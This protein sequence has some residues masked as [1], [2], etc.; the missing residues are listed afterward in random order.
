MEKHVGDMKPIASK[1]LLS[2]GED[3]IMKEL[4]QIALFCK[5]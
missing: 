5:N 3:A 2:S 4:R 1:N